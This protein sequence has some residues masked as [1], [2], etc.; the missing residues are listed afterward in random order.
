M[1]T[2]A[3]GREALEALVVEAYRLDRYD[4]F[5]IESAVQV[6]HML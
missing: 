3:V 6:N 5:D 2:C 4:N 1:T